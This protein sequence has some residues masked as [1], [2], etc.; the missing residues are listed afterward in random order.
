MKV[1]KIVFQQSFLI[2]G[3]SHNNHFCTHRSP[4]LS[5]VLPSLEDHQSPMD[6]DDA[7]DDE[8]AFHGTIASPSPSPPRQSPPPPPPMP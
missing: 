3:F 2:I 8:D 5:L 4:N 6:D 1:N 7:L